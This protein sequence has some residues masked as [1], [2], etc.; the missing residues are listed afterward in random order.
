[1]NLEEVK[2]E[3]APS[4]SN[5]NTLIEE[6]EERSVELIRSWTSVERMAEKEMEK[7]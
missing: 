3:I 6:I 7:G 2:R 5:L 4:P 1:M